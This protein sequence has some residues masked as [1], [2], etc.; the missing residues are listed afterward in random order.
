LLR[1]ITDMDTAT[2][3]EAR[4]HPAVRAARAHLEANPAQLHTLRELARSAGVSVS[5]LTALF[6]EEC[7]V[8][9]MRYLQQLRMERACW[10]LANPYVRVREVAASCGYEDVNYFT[11][12]FHR[13]FGVSPGRWRKK[14]PAA[15]QSQRR[16]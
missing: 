2:G 11:R 10:L 15:E 5:H 8:G 16:S 4:F 1:R 14:R 12:L 3:S 13:R 9:A 6:A 7:G